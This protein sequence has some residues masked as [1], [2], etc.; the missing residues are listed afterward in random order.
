MATQMASAQ[1]ITLADYERAEVT[2]RAEEGRTSFLW[3]AA[4]YVVVNIGL[5]IINLVFASEFLWFIFPLLGWGIGL[6]AHYLFGWRFSRRETRQWQTK[7]E[8]HAA[9]MRSARPA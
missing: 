9:E 6:T 1:G 8:Q 2:L 3:H 5:I 7:V 4:I